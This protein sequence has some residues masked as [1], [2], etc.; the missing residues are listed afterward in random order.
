MAM[1]IPVATMKAPLREAQA[2]RAARL[3]ALV[4][5]RV[6]RDD[7]RRAARRVV[8]SVEEEAVP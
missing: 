5:A 2:T 4:R 8:S 1:A 7:P 6:W 3:P